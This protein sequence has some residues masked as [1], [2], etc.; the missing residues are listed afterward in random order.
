MKKVFVIIMATIGLS[1]CSQNKESNNQQQL[2]NTSKPMYDINQYIFPEAKNIKADNFEEMVTNNVKHYTSEPIYYF[3]INKQNCVIEVSTND[4]L[5]HKDYELSNVIT[6]IELG[7]ILKSGIQTVT[8]R[9]YPVGDLINKDLGLENQPPSNKLSDKAKVDIS[10]VM[11]DNKSKKGFDDEKV[12]TTQVSPKEAA[13]KS[14]YEFSFNFNAEVPY[15]FEGWTKGQDLRK[16]DQELVRKKAIEF[17]EII[18]EIYKNKDL[19]A[20]LK[21]EYPF[22]VRVKQALYRQRD[23]IEGITDEY[24]TDLN[25]VYNV[26]PINNFRMDYMGNGK[27]L[28]LVTNSKDQNLIGGG[29]LILK[30]NEGIN[31]PGI[32]LYLPEGRDLATQ[33]FMMWK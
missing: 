33:G 7:H 21:M 31:Q 10:V 30:Y 27:L 4:V 12:I 11:M 3:R 20:L 22:T 1:G 13:G 14:Y 29:A 28:C 15:E 5:E 18:G 24:R 8:V 23:L 9:M 16:L 6:P 19:D 26:E 2:T 25:E 17:Y 32:T